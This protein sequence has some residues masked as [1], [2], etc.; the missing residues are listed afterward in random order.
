[1]SASASLRKCRCNRT[2]GTTRPQAVL[3]ALPGYVSKIDGLVTAVCPTWPLEANM[4]RWVI[5]GTFMFA[6]AIMLAQNDVC[7]TA[8]DAG[9]RFRCYSE[10][11]LAEIN[12]HRNDL[13]DQQLKFACGKMKKMLDR[14]GPCTVGRYTDVDFCARIVR[15][16]EDCIFRG[17]W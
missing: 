16:R 8:I 10:Q 17:Y 14:Y 1:M 4:G 12:A 6:P 11:A 2:P 3:L 9:L 5:L 7:V 13:P 15:T